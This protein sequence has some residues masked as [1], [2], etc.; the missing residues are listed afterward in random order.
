MPKYYEKLMPCISIR[1]PWAD[2][3]LNGVKTVENRTTKG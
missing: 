2:L 3:I 1:Q